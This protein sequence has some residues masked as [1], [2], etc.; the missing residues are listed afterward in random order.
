MRPRTALFAFL[1]ILCGWAA[2]L[3]QKPFH[4]YP[5]EDRVPLPPDWRVEHEWVTARLMYRDYGGRFGRGAWSIDYP[6]GDRNLIEGVR[7]LTRIDVRSVEQAVSLDD[8]GDV[9]YWPWL[10]AVEPGQWDIN[11]AEGKEL[12]EYL[13]RGGFLMVDDFHGTQQW[14]NFEEGIR[15]AFPTE[16]IEDLPADD[17]IFHMLSDVDLKVQIPGLAALYNGRTYEQSSDP[18]PRWRGIRDAKGRIIVAICHNM[19]LGDA[20]EHSN[21]PG[22]PAEYAVAAHHV[23]QNYAT[24]DLTH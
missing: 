11:E 20:W 18:F 14:A 9:F 23:L 24:Y 19:D 17:P 3:A 22:Y 8:S 5:G 10:Y 21:E 16:E 2:L 13:N 4:E 7:R 12:R 6:G 1:L 15:M